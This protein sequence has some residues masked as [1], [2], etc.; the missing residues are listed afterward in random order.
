MNSYRF[1]GSVLIFL[2]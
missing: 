2:G 1:G